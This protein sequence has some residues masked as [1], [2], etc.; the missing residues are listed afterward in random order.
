MLY[1]TLQKIKY[2]CSP[3][4]PG[5]SSHDGFPKTT[6]GWL[7]ADL[8]SGG[9]QREANSRDCRCNNPCGAREKKE[10]LCSFFP[11]FVSPILSPT[12]PACMHITSASV[13]NQAIQSPWTWMDPPSSFH[14]MPACDCCEAA[15]SAHVQAASS[16]L[17]RS[18]PC[19]LCLCQPL[20]FVNSTEQQQTNLLQLD[21]FF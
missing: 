4:H 8:C 2:G 12:H 18:S 10:S 17:R 14:H 3:C 11:L 19:D 21:I 13:A 20:S 9:R 5:L 15:C 16:P 6:R 1:I 7:P